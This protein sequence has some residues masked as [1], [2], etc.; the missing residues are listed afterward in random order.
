MLINI[1]KLFI[2]LIMKAA[3]ITQYGD[4]GVVTISQDVPRPPAGKAA[5]LVEVHAASLNPADSFIRLGY[6]HKMM[7]LHFPATLG[8]DIAGVVVEAD[9]GFGT[10][11]TGDRVYGTASV[12]AG[13]SGA[14][15][16]YA[17]APAGTLAKAPTGLSFAEAAA[18][19]LA[20]VSALQALE[21]L[22][23]PKGITL[24]IQG[25]SGGVGTFAVKMAKH[26]GARV[27]AS[28]RGSAADYVTSLGADQ[29]IDFEKV[30]FLESLRDCDAVFDTVGGEAYKAS[31]AVLKKGGTIVS[32]G[33]QPDAE[34]AAKFGVTA[35]G[36]RTDVTTARLDHLARLVNEGAMKVHLDRVFPLDKIRD[37]FVAREAGH[38][39]GK[40]VLQIRE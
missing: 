15:A 20:G 2:F 5:V 22:K 25:G 35:F 26:L 12:M 4:A 24:F 17:S 32:M 34:L 16:E 36:M 31:F 7:P 6:M 29:V 21:T 18:L 9:P 19:P 40:I 38:L 28:C 14:F 23:L 11:R 33:A 8:I 37:A 39:K 10:I 27:V 3:Q 30:G 1:F 13:G